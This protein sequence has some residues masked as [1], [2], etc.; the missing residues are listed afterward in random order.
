[1]QS[2]TLGLVRVRNQLSRYFLRSYA[3]LAYNSKPSGLE[4]KEK[5]ASKN[6]DGS[7]TI[8]SLSPGE[9]TNLTRIFDSSAYAPLLNSI[10]FLHLLRNKYRSKL[11]TAPDT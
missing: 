9:F 2:T 6:D 4:D 10:D 1:M 5:T 7:S 11:D 8:S 3:G